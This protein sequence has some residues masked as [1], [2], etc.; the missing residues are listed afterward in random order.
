MRNRPPGMQKPPAE[1]EECRERS[2]RGRGIRAPRR[3]VSCIES[4]ERAGWCVLG[5]E[6]VERRGEIA[7]AGI[8]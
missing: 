5:R 4:R 2:A 8:R 6:V 3:T 7:L 1:H